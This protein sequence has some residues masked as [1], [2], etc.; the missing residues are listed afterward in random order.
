MESGQW[1]G[2]FHGESSLTSVSELDG[3][4]PASLSV[5]TKAGVIPVGISS[6]RSSLRRPLSAQVVSVREGWGQFSSQR[7]GEAPLG[8]KATETGKKG[9]FM[10]LPELA[11]KES[12]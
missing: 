9:P 10:K 6:P 5:S 1:A 2:R 7:L 4:V 11:W 12:D 3:S 8:V